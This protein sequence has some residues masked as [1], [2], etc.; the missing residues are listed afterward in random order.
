MLTDRVVICMK[1]GALYSADYV[2]VL[3]N[4]CKAN[5]SGDF[6]FVCLTDHAEDLANGIEAFPIP[7][8]GLEEPHWK[9]GAWPKISVFKQQLY[10]LQGRGL[11]IDLDTVIWG[12]L[13]EFFE[14]E[15]DFIALDSAPWRYVNSP[16]RTGTG[17]FAFDFGKMGWVVEKLLTQRD[18]LINEY[19]IE[20]DYLHSEISD[21]RYWQQEW[22]K[23]YKYHL[24]QPL[25]IDRF[26]GPSQPNQSVKIICFHGK[27][28]PIDLI[29]PPK[30]NWDRFPHY[31][32]GP[33][34]WMVEY[35]VTNG[36][37][38]KQ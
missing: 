12:S 35:W 31:G 16:P 18:K 10:G 36:G 22:I 21:I 11:F 8:I 15:G 13:D 2:N 28:R 23:S 29:C 25:V 19:K 4:A 24:R 26:K 20:Q 38:L 33:V 5:I 30:G 14:C 6:R 7:D 17:I 1:W 34:P 9:H 27:P 3:F 32:T 37:S